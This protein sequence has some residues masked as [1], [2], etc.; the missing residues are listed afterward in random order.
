MKAYVTLLVVVLTLTAVPAASAQSTGDG[1][2]EGSGVGGSE[3][4]GEETTAADAVY[5]RENGDAVLVYEASGEVETETSVSYGADMSSGLAHFLANGT[6]RDNGFTG[7]FSFVGK[8]TSLVANGS[9]ETEEVEAIEDLSLD[10]TGEVN[11]TNSGMSAEL[12]S[13]LSPTVAAAMPEASTEG[14]IMVTGLD[15]FRSS[16]SASY[17]TPSGGPSQREVWTFDLSGTDGGYVIDARERRKVRGELTPV[18]DTDGSTTLEG[19]E[20]VEIWG[21]PE[22]AR[23]KLR[24]RYAGFAENVS[25]SVDVTVESHSFENA[26]V[27]TRF[28]T[29]RNESVVDVEYTVEYTGVQE[30]LAD[31][32][33]DEFPGNVSEETAENLAQSVRD[34]NVNRLRF[35]S[36]S[37]A[38]G[39]NFN[40]T[41]DVENY[42]DVA[43]AYLELTSEMSSGAGMGPGAGVGASPSGSPFAS[44]EFVEESINRSR[45]QMEAAEAAGYVSRWEWSASLEAPSNAGAGTGV[46]SGVGSGGMS[47]ATASLDAE[48]TTENWEAYVNELEDR[49]VPTPVNRAFDLHVSK[50][51]NGGLEG[52]V[53]WEAGGESL[54]ERYSETMSAYERV[55]EESEDVDADF[56]RDL[57]DSGF[58]IA[59]MD[60]SVDDEGWSLEAGAAFENGTALSSAIETTEGI[61]VTEVVGQQENGGVT[62]YVKVEGF[63]DE[64][65][66]EAVRS[67]EQVD[68]E[69]EVNLPG[70]WNREFPETDTE[71]AASYLGV[72]LEEENTPL[73]GFGFVVAIV[74]LTVVAV[75]VAARRR[76]DG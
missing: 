31:S 34:M 46:G 45:Q 59:K 13:T 73:P 75:V 27:E 3:Q 20:P 33:V 36:V 74:A 30:G 64:T 61:K 4:M 8:P 40:W 39:S 62:T 12:D 53:R 26:T 63:V 43:L 38:D 2:G 21:T 68:D 71:A 42:N 18:R 47:S 72:E 41:V 65:T 52:E 49:G 6:T 16:G 70:D 24:E 29:T 19:T 54:Y 55:L 76:R 58:G 57:R 17:T 10:V 9:F 7:D 23:E 15:T 44:Q 51:E 69:T 66:E 35:A 11:R 22:K 67:R 28:G 5:V 37:D 56:L 48:L 14:E 32:I 50:A 1:F 25:G 60:A